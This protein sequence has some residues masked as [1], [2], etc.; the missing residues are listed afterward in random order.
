MFS[1]AEM[2][3]TTTTIGIVE[4]FIKRFRNLDAKK[5]KGLLVHCIL[6]NNLQMDEFS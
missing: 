1:P 5:C 2:S 6:T 3:E 4:M